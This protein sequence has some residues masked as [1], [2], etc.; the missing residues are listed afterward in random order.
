[1]FGASSWRAPWR[2][3]RCRSS[4]WRS[5]GRCIKP[6][7]LLVFSPGRTGSTLLVRLLSAAGVALCVGAGCADAVGASSRRRSFRLLPRDT[8]LQIA[9][10]CLAGL[11]RERGGG[12][13]RQVAQPVQWAAA[14]AGGCGTWLPGGV[15]AAWVS[16][17]GGLAASQFCRAAGDGGLDTAPGDGCAGQAAVRGRRCERAVVRDAG[18]ASGGGVAG[19]CAQSRVGCACGRRCRCSSI[20]RRARFWRARRW[21][22]C[23]RRRWTGF[24][25]RLRVPGRRRGRVRS[26]R[27]ARRGHLAEMFA[28]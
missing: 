9:R 7:P 17:L 8:R 13:V 15:H 11:A 24:L 16:V 6:A 2:R 14:G 4:G 23:L 26:G 25:R 22:R 27:S 10:G 12:L 21:R 3:R 19:V 18:R 20:R 1:M 5:W 28:T